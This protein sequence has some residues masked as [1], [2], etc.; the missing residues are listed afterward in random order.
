MKAEILYDVLNVLYSTTHND[1]PEE[2][3][4]GIDLL[5]RAMI[6]GTTGEFIIEKMRRMIELNTE[7]RG[8]LYSAILGKFWE[9]NFAQ[10]IPFRKFKFDY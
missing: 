2:R 3:E 8:K 10:T 4:K 6:L 5:E 1:R 7:A 9:R